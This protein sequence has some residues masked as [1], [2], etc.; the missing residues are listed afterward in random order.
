MLAPVAPG[1]LGVGVATGPLLPAPTLPPVAPAPI[2]DVTLAGLPASVL[3]AR[4]VA[5]ESLSS[6][7]QAPSAATSKHDLNN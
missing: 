4:T 5:V 7:S 2:G 3:G 1:D 6:P